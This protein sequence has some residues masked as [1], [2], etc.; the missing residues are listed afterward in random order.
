[1]KKALSQRFRLAREFVLTWN[2]YNEFP[3]GVTGIV[4]ARL[5]TLLVFA[6]GRRRY[7]RTRQRVKRL[8]SMKGSCQGPLLVLGAGPSLEALSPEWLTYFREQGGMVMGSNGFAYVEATLGASADYLVLADPAYFDSAGQG[9]ES[10]AVERDRAMA[11]AFE[12]TLF[13][14]AAKEVPLGRGSRRTI[15]FEFDGLEGF[16]WRADPTRPRGFSGVTILSAISI[17]LYLGYGPIYVCGIDYDYFR[18]F[19]MDGM[20][21]IVV[22]RS[23]YFEESESYWNA[24][25]KDMADVLFD[26]A[27]I[28]RD[29]KNFASCDVV[30]LGGPSSLVDSFPRAC[31]WRPKPSSQD[32]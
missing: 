2:S 25:G 15:Y 18:T 1:M 23:H 28:L 17:G 7:P 30:N 26:A 24:M 16:G 9:D 19:Q 8:R 20:N 13:V 27:R 22:G 31:P 21:R 29:L 12:G 4:V 14:P 6:Y 32:E 3:A 11:R 10:A 5:R